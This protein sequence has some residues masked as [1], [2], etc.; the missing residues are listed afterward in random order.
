MSNQ[1]PAVTFEEIRALLRNL[2]GPDLDAGTAALQRERQLTKP[3]GA[4]GRLE[5]LAQWVATWQ[6]QH[7]PD[8]RRP[9]VAVFAGNH[10]V[11]AR[12]VSAYPAAVTAQMVAN[13][14]NGGAAVNQLCETADAD[15]RVYELDLDNPT[16]DFTQGPAMGE[17]E[18]CRTM[19]YGMMAVEMGVQLLALG[20]M[21][22]G[23]STS[24]AALC[25][26]LFGG[27]AADWTGRGTGVD[28]EGLARKVAAVEA[29]LA[30]NPQAKEDPLEALRRLGGYELAAIA[31]AILAARV[32]R[33]PVLLDGFACTA[34][35]AVL[36]KA[37][38]RALDHCVVAHRS[39]EPGHG[40]LLEAL[41]KEALLDLGMRLGEG[42]GAALAIN[43]VKSAVACHA[44]MATFADAGVSNREG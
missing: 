31:G 41:G 43:I 44:G 12:G 10:G 25:L 32:A 3:A 18:C 7:P 17:E 15:L 28:D 8:I 26:A 11:A 1:Q 13:F 20:E 4:L 9:R 22:I 34:A 37:D 24:A 19:A 29:G 42:S 33:V 30:A 27:E 35:A 21:G 6:G 2:P 16:A 38:R 5:E 23:N 40:R 14:Q 39:V 36:F